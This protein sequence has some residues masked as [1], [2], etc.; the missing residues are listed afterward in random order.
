[1]QAFEKSGSNCGGGPRRSIDSR[2][3]VRLCAC[4]YVYACLCA[5][6]RAW[7]RAGLRFLLRREAGLPCLDLPDLLR[8]SLR[9]SGGVWRGLWLGHG[10]GMAGQAWAGFIISA[11]PHMCLRVPYLSQSDPACSCLI[12]PTKAHYMG[13]CTERTRQAC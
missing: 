2:A 4:A 3:P 9:G 12:Q 13:A 8:A 6:A 10:T 5:P 1:M 11:Y 7:A